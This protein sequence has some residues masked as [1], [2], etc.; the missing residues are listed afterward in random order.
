MTTIID[1][2]S[3]VIFKLFA[4]R[5][6]VS[7]VTQKCSPIW[8]IWPWLLASCF[9]NYKKYWASTTFHFR[10]ALFLSAIWENEIGATICQTS[11]VGV[12]L[13]TFTQSDIFSS[14]FFFW[15]FSNHL[16]II[17]DEK[18]VGPPSLSMHNLLNT[19]FILK[20]LS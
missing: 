8:T 12:H 11:H 5:K 4:I 6:V 18:S 17:L 13:W 7:G 9:L 3:W 1:I 10:F 20:I 19:N 15:T 16:R 14:P 2:K